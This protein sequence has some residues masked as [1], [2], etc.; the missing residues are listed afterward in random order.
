R[1]EVDRVIA[2]FSGETDDRT[3]SLVRSLRDENVLVDVVPRL[4]EL[5]GPRADIHLVEGLPLLTVPPARLRRSSRITK[6]LIDIVAAGVL[7]VFTAPV[8]VL[9]A[10]RIRRESPGPV[11]FRQTRLGM[12]S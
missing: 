7:L 5:V 8:F 10:F 3:M 1:G 11:F 2:A 12:N 4:Y 6:R 9:A